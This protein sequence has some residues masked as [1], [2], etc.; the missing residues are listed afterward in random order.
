[1]QKD[2]NLQMAAHDLLL[3]AHMIQ[4]QAGGWRRALSKVQVK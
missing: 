3:I 4:A 2:L 1:M